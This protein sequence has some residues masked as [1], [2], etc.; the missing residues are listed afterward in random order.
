MLGIV[1]PSPTWVRF[2]AVKHDLSVINH[3]RGVFADSGSMLHV[4]QE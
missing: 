3:S 1:A 4:R 2:V